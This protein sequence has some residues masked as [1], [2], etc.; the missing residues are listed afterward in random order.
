MKTTEA[1]WSPSIPKTSLPGCPWTALYQE[2]FFT[3]F[4]DGR[5]LPVLEGKLGMLA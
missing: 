4:V 5:L 1:S 2:D 3:A